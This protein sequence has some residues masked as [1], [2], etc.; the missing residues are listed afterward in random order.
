MLFLRVMPI[1]T[2]NTDYAEFM[3]RIIK[4][5]VYIVDNGV[6]EV[7]A[8]GVF[9]AAGKPSEYTQRLVERLKELD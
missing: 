7:I 3:S 6:Y 8:F 4:L 5:A 2:K 9:H 1:L